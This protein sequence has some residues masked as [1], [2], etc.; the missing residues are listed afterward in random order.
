MNNSSNFSLV[1]QM[2]CLRDKTVYSKRLVHVFRVTLQ[3]PG[4]WNC[5][6]KI[7][8]AMIIHLFQIV[9][10]WNLGNETG[11]LFC[12]HLKLA[13]AGSPKELALPCKTTCRIATPLPLVVCSGEHFL[14]F[15]ALSDVTRSF[16]FPLQIKCVF[17]LHS[18]SH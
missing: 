10:F 13:Q 14:L 1:T 4:Q 7:M 9:P 16:S 17:P 2:E 18:F 5:P 15:L 8:L 12:S 3:I 11:A 6:W